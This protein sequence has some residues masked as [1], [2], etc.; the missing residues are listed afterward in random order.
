MSLRLVKLAASLQ[1]KKYRS[2]ENLFV[3]EGEKL[4]LDF[5]DFFS[6][7]CILALEEW[8]N[9]Y[10]EISTVV[11]SKTLLKKAS[12]L[13]HPASVLAIFHTPEQKPFNTS[14]LPALVLDTLQDPG[15]FGTI[16]RTAAWFG[17]HHIICSPETADVYNPKVVQATMGALPLVTVHYQP[18]APFLRQMNE[19][20]IITIGTFLQG[21]NIYQAQIPK[22]SIVVIGNEGKGISEALQPLINLP[23]HIPKLGTKSPESLNAAISAAIVCSEIARTTQN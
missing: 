7:K 19:E 8:A 1:H 18:L 17:I 12:S 13:Q 21:K 4:V 9:K 5:L 15:N 3:A 2:K 6:P 11:V 14:E 10:P 23:V 22:R 16:V 20:G